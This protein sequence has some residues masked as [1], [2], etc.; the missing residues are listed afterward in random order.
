MLGEVFD[1]ILQNATNV[2]FDPNPGALADESSE[3]GINSDRIA[4]LSEATE[5]L[6]THAPR[7]GD[8][9][10][11]ATR[12]DWPLP[13]QRPLDSE[14]IERTHVRVGGP[15]LITDQ[16]DVGAGE[17]STPD[18]DG[19]SSISFHRGERAADADLDGPCIESRR[20]GWEAPAS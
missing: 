20:R 18:L 5:P 17:A 1:R 6:L 2:I 13:R 15:K 8:E 4:C 11:V 3:A 19:G 14:S 9:C 12:A 10:V 16:P 7:A